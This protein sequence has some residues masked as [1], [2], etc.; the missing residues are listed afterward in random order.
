MYHLRQSIN[1]IIGLGGCFYFLCRQV[2]YDL[3]DT[4]ESPLDGNVYFYQPLT[5][6][7]VCVMYYCWQEAKNS[8]TKT[9][10]WFFFAMSSNWIFRFYFNYENTTLKSEYICL[11]AFMVGMFFKFGKYKKARVE[12][13]AG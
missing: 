12:T 10:W 1:A 11:A 2:Y 9:A 8:Y 5:T 6:M 7:I 3:V 13:Q 4:K